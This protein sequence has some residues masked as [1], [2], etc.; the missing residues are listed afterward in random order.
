MMSDGCVIDGELHVVA[1]ITQDNDDV[2]ILNDIWKLQKLDTGK[3]AWLCIH[4]ECSISERHNHVVVSIP[5][6]RMFVHGGEC[7]S[8]L[9][10]CW[11]Y[12]A[13]HN[14][15]Q[16]VPTPSGSSPCPRSSHSAAF[17]DPFVVLFGGVTSPAAFAVDPIAAEDFQPVYLNDLWILDTSSAECTWRMISVS[18][19]APSPRDLPSVVCVQEVTGE[20]GDVLIFGGYG[21]YMEESDDEEEEEEEG[22]GKVSGDGDD[23]GGEDLEQ[24]SVGMAGSKAEAVAAMIDTV[25][26]IRLEGVS[27]KDDNAAEAT[28]VAVPVVGDV[29]GGYDGDGSGVGE[30]YLSDAW[31]VNIHT[32]MSTEV[33]LTRGSGIVVEQCGWRGARLGV[34]GPSVRTASTPEAAAGTMGGGGGGRGPPSSSFI[35]TGG[36][37][38][39]KL[40][41]IVE[42]LQIFRNPSK[43]YHS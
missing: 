17:C 10:D 40:G 27:D 31:I 12:Y 6:S 14:S 18:G 25:G 35:M 23:G 34:V 37:N 30:G 36:F 3:Y 28:A 22:S 39:E 29:N 1:G 16:Q 38:G 15:F 43:S 19:I 2:L 5:G 33:D 20:S 11:M 4:E 8:F 32:L 7:G 24:S 21:L 41:G 13:L 42:G 9:G 26:S